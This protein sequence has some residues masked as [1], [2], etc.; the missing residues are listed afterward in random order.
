MTRMQLRKIN[1]ISSPVASRYSSN[2]PPNNFGC[3]VM[4][5]R[6]IRLR[7]GTS[8]FT[9]SVV[10]EFNDESLASSFRKSSAFASNLAILDVPKMY[11][12][13]FYRD[14]KYFLQF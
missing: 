3:P 4:F 9:K 6:P 1:G 5:I 8:V 11:S 12:R 7:F 2:D 10:F 14:K 13:I